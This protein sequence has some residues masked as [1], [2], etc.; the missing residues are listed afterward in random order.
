MRKSPAQCLEIIITGVIYG[1]V[2]SKYVYVRIF[3]GTK[4]MST[5]TWLAVGTWAAIT[6][7]FWVIA[8]IIAESIPNSNTCLPL[9]PRFLRLGLR[10]GSA[11]YSD[12]L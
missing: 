8:F 9:F 2:A 10:T 11:A 6:L 5:R 3:R 4:H 12:C 7:T 1:H